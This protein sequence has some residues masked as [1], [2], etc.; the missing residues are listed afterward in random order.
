M[1][2]ESSLEQSKRVDP[3]RVSKEAFMPQ[4][5]SLKNRTIVPNR[6]FLAY[7]WHINRPIYEKI[8]AELHKS[9]PVYFYAVGR[10]SGQ[11]AEA[12]LGKIES[13]MLSSTEAVF[14]ASRGNANVSLE[15]GLAY[16]VPDLKQYLLIDQSSLPS[17]INVGTPIVSDLAGSMQ[18]RWDLAKPSTLKEH[19]QAIAENHPFTTRFRRYCRDR[20]LTR[21]QYRA[22]LKVIRLF[23]AREAILRREA[24]DQLQSEWNGKTVKDIEKLLT[25]MHN[26]GLITMTPGRE[27]ASRISVG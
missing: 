16:F 3:M 21:G 6:I 24:I 12:L 14:D 20:R 7:Q 2:R 5:V 26:A 15:Y 9:F 10:P 22:P 1:Q 27:W 8:C 18:N 4:N 19:L 23:D 25:D 11:Q 17:Q 13:V